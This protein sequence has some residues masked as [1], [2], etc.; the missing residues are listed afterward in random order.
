[1]LQQSRER[2][3]GSRAGETRGGP[4]GRGTCAQGHKRHLPSGRT[5]C[6][7]CTKGGQDSDHLLLDVR[8][9]VDR[10]VTCLQSVPADP[11]AVGDPG[12]S[13]LPPDAGTATLLPWRKSAGRRQLH[14]WRDG[15]ALPGEGAVRERKYC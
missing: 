5:G 10:G 11:R 13:Y 12:K 14:P 7:A 15:G 2:A 6:K 8:A 1:M 3:G 4:E 9:V